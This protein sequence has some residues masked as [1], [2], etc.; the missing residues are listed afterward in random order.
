MKTQPRTYLPRS[1]NRSWADRP[2]QASRQSCHLQP[3]SGSVAASVGVPKLRVYLCGHVWCLQKVHQASFH[4]QNFHPE[5]SCLESP[6]GKPYRKAFNAQHTMHY[7]WKIPFYLHETLVF[8]S[9]ELPNTICCT[10]VSL[11]NSS[12]SKVKANRPCDNF[13]HTKSTWINLIKLKGKQLPH[14]FDRFIIPKT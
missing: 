12:A 7:R 1:K 6:T 13:S 4:P 3:M 2:Q 11:H 5:S 9:F 8:Q 10:L 14:L